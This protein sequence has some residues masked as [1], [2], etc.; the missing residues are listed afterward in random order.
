MRILAMAT[1]TL[2]LVG[3]TLAGATVLR[4]ETQ[5]PAEPQAQ[6]AVTKAE[7]AASEAAAA[8]SKAA[9]EA[10]AAARA[11]ADAAADAAAKASDAAAAAVHSVAEGATTGALPDPAEP[12]VV[13]AAEAGAEA[14]AE[15]GADAAASAADKAAEAAGKAAATAAEPTETPAEAPAEAT[16]EAGTDPAAPPPVIAPDVNAPA[17]SEAEPGVLSSWIT[18]RNIWTTNRPSTIVWVAPTLTER[19]GDWQNIAKVA[20]IVLDDSGQVVGYIADIG[21]FL[22]IG[23]KKVLLGVGSIHLVTI[24]DNSFF[25]TNYTKEELEALP[26]FDEKTVRK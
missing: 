1:S 7:K 24:G 12:V 20:D 21:G 10:E 3:L 26:D 2:M 5:V 25:A 9:L 22:G 14:A 18:S 8:A 19:P 16:A 23:A 13:P 11:A 15:T 17:I 4:A 6:G